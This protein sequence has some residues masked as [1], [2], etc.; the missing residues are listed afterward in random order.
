V[1]HGDP[2][3]PGVEGVGVAQLAERAQG[4]DDDVLRDV[5]SLLAAPENRGRVRTA[6]VQARLASTSA[7]PV[8]PAR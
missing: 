3:Y 2:V 8:S 7:A 4:F 1:A 6:S 5:G